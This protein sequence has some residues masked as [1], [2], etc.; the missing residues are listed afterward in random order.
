MPLNEKNIM[1]ILMS[2]SGKLKYCWHDKQMNAILASKAVPDNE[3]DIIRRVA[4][5][6]TRLSY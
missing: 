1:T 4:W 3:N 5:A 6:F 2:K